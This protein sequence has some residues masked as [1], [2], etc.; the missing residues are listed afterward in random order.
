MNTLVKNNVSVTFFRKKFFFLLR[1]NPKL[2]NVI[3]EVFIQGG[4]AYVIGGYIRSLLDNSHV[5]D[6][7]IIVDLPSSKLEE[8]VAI[9]CTDFSKNRHGGIKM[10]FNSLTVDVWCLNDN[11]AFRENVVNYNVNYNENKV[12]ESIAAGCFYNYDALVVNMLS[13]NFNIR[14]YLDCMHKKEL[15]ILK[16]NPNYANLNPT[17]EANILRA[18]YLKRVHDF[19]FSP[20]VSNY[21]VSKMP[22]ISLD[23]KESLQRLID[24]LQMYP[25]YNLLTA[26]YLKKEYMNLLFSQR[27]TSLEQY[28]LSYDYFLSENDKT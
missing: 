11:W 2:A 9:Y 13:G 26:E 5:R 21:I 19:K 25:K 18:F 24:K 20:N 8:I 17:T 10:T 14:Y 16:S 1:N 22:T 6:I 12:L 7:D 28:L 4:H 23:I 15:S 3:Y 27:E